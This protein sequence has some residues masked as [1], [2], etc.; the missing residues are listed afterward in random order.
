MQGMMRVSCG[1]LCVI[2][3]GNRLLL[4]INRN[5]RGKGQA[6]LKPIGGA[7]HFDRAG[8]PVNLT[9]TLA[10]PLTPE[11]RLFL[12]ADQLDAFSVWFTARQA[13]EISPFRELREELVDEYHAMTDLTPADVEIT[14]LRT[15]TTQRLSDRAGF[16]GTLTHSIQEIYRVRFLRLYHR[17]ALMQAAPDSGLYWVTEAEIRAGR[18]NDAIT[19]QAETLLDSR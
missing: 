12:P 7:L 5:L 13:R 6:V 10:D 3:N 19:I 17:V 9:P 16:T 2:P 18:L 1:A 14:Y 11:L 8:L 15:V 4:G